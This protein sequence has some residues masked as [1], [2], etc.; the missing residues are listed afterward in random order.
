[1][2]PLSRP[3]AICVPMSERS[4]KLLAELARELIE[5][6]RDLELAPLNLGGP[7]L[8][9]IQE[10]V[11][12]RVLAVQCA[13]VD[14]VFEVVVDAPFERDAKPPEVEFVGRD[15]GIRVQ[16]AEIEVQPGVKVRRGTRRSGATAAETGLP[17]P[18][19]A[20]GTALPDTRTTPPDAF[21]IPSS[22]VP[23][24]PI[25]PP[26]CLRPSAARSDRRATGSDR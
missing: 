10:H 13:D 15:L 2:T 8:P 25:A 7:E 9:V 12:P 5:T 3:G 22:A 19:P 18:P 24:T 16:R 6:E 23:R 20:V 14:F 21:R 1:M 11:A 26:P 17:A 4:M